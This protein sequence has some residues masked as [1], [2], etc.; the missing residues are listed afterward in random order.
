MRGDNSGDDGVSRDWI[1]VRFDRMEARFQESHQRL[2]QEMNHGFHELATQFRGHEDEDRKV[3]DRLLRIETERD[4]EK[5]I[6]SKHGALAGSISAGLVI[7]LV[8]AVKRLF[9][10]HP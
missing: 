1:D 10:S 4:T 6:A 9:V 8:E 3:A 7:G 5:S 2:R